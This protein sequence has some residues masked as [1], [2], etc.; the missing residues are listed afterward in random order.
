[1][2]NAAAGTLVTNSGVSLAIRGAILLGMLLLNAVLY[3]AV[4]R[5]ATPG[6]VGAP[7]LVPGAAG[8]SGFHIAHHYWIWARSASTPT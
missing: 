3:F 6:R 5:V 1:M 8:L 7:D 4:F 2:L